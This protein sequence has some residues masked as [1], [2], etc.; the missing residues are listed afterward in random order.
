MMARAVGIGDGRTTGLT[1]GV[2]ATAA[3]LTVAVQSHLKAYMGIADTLPLSRSSRAGEVV[4]DKLV[5]VEKLT[6][7]LG[8]VCRSSPTSDGATSRVLVPAIGDGIAGIVTVLTQMPGTFLDSSFVVPSVFRSRANLAW[9]LELLTVIG[10]ASP[11]SAHN[12][13]RVRLFRTFADPL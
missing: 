2:G 1:R 10:R 7:Y 8:N 3:I 12:L 13:F 4:E 5:I 9:S 11:E 6:A